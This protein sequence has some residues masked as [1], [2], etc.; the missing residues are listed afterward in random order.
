M[1]AKIIFVVFLSIIALIT[2]LSPLGRKAREKWQMHYWGKSMIDDFD[3][4]RKN[5]DNLTK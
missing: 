1:I 2:G 5:I 3:E 4:E